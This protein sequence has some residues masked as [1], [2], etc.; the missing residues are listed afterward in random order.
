MEVVALYREK[1]VNPLSG[2]LPILIQL[3]FL[4]GMFDLLKSVFELRGASFI[5]GWI[6]NLTAPDVLFSWNYPVFFFGT[7][8]HLLPLLLG[9]IMYVQ[10]KF[11]SQ[12]PKDPAL[13]TDSQKQQKMMGNI[14]VI[15][16]SVMFYH[17]PSGLNIYWLSS[18]ALGIF[19]QWFSKRNLKMKKSS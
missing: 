13:M 2:C 14:M 17:F 16:F 12:T 11:A 1:K 18:T 8:F 10:Q 3:P 4:I 7:S 5:P 6:N 19:Q 9:A 15:V